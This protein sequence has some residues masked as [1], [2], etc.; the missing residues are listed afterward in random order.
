MSL[1]EIAQAT[2]RIQDTGS[3]VSPLGKVVDLSAAQN[4]AVAK[5]EIFT[6]DDCARAL[7]EIRSPKDPACSGQVTVADESTQL[8][9]QR[10]ARERPPCILSFASARNVGG[11]F[12]NGSKAQEEDIHR[13]CGVYRCLAKATKYYEANRAVDSLLYTDHIIYSPLVPWFR[14]NGRDLLEEPF[15]ASIITAPA[16]NAGQYLRRNPNGHADIHQALHRRAGYVLAVAIARKETHLVLGAWGCGVFQNAPRDVA[17][18][19]HYW[20]YERHFKSH[21]E[22]VHFA[23]LDKTQNQSLLRA[24]QEMYP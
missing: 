4:Q 14:V 3:Y 23:V 2:L 10:L 21:F 19:F 12:I 7:E 8:A 6:P 18:I 11:G 9:A 1:R 15:Q 13:C 22:H 17:G 24:F 20:L 5:T 16:P